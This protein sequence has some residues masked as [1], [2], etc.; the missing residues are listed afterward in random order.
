MKKFWLRFKQYYKDRGAAE[1]H[2][3]FTSVISG[4]IASLLLYESSVLLDLTKVSDTATLIASLSGV[5]WALIRSLM[6]GTLTA[7][8]PKVFPVRTIKK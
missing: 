7:L 2:S 1:L 8:F 6:N 5:F 3:F 4:T